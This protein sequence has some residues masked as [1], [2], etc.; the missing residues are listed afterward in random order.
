MLLPFHLIKT[1]FFP[2]SSTTVVNYPY[3]NL[4]EPVLAPHGLA[5][6]LVGEVCWIGVTFRRRR[7]KER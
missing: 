1:S 7:G 3:Y 5:G 6:E 2:F 4:R